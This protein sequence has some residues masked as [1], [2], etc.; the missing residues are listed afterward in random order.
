MDTNKLTQKTKILIND[1]YALAEQNRNLV[2]MPE[3]ILS[4]ALRKSYDISRNIIASC[5]DNIEGVAGDVKAAIDKLPTGR[6]AGTLHFDPGAGAIIAAGIQLAGEYG[7]SFLAIDVLMHAIASSDT[8]P[9]KILAGHGATTM[10]IKAAI[11]ALRG[12]QTSDS[13]NFEET[14]ESLKKYGTD[15]TELASRGKLDPVIGRDDE[16]ERAI[17]ILSMRKKNNPVLIGEPGVGKTAIVE[18]LAQRIFRCEVPESIK[19][20]KVISLDISGLLAGAKFRGEFE[21][22]LKSVLKEAMSSRDII[23]FIDEIHSIIGAGATEGGSMDASNMLKP[24]LARGEIRCIGATT[25]DEYRM[26]IERDPAL[27]RRFQPI[28]L[29]QPN[30]EDVLAILRGLK[31]KYELFHGVQIQ[32]GALVATTDLARHIQGRFSPDKEIDIID[33]ASSMV[34]SHVYSKPAPI[35]KLHK[36]IMRLQMEQSSLAKETSEESSARANEI[37]AELLLLTKERDDLEGIWQEERDSITNLTAAKEQLEQ[38]R[39]ELQVAQKQSNWTRAGEL[40]YSTI[41]ELEEKIRLMSSKIGSNQFRQ[42]VTKGTVA[43]VVARM[44]GIPLDTIVNEERGKLIEMESHLEKSVVGQPIALK[45]VANAIRRARTGMQDPNR[46][47]GSFLFL[48]PT[49]VGKTELAKALARFLFCDPAAILRIDMSEYMEKH[50]VSNLI[51]APPGYVGY[52]RGGLLTETTR[53]RPYQI[54]L[55]D[56][57]EK[58]HVEVLNLLL[59]IL[60]EGHVTDGRGNKVSFKNTIIILTSNIGSEVIAQADDVS[61]VSGEVM[62]VVQGVLSPEFINRL[63][64][65]V[66]FNKLHISNMQDI[67]KIQ[68]GDLC[69]RIKNKYNMDL[70]VDHKVVEFLA[71]KGYDPLYGA[72]PLKRAIQHYLQDGLSSMILGGELSD[73]CSVVVTISN[74]QLKFSVQNSGST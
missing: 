8:V 71:E 18:G 20:A 62:R 6:A 65:I 54:V 5:V 60:D 22:R 74:E 14:R 36:Q 50:S 67:I 10:K 29:S 31:E 57:I 64:E 4:V 19:N 45:A 40:M 23:L 73:G 35:S 39:Q 38:I 72:R 24:H 42:E 47:L 9:S 66:L 58:A 37:A 25:L 43:Q 55:F 53:R 1:S 7:D 3:H 59:Q 16:I 11:L 61:M 34:R 17:Q 51:G 49:G 63:D 41:P 33:E 28:F 70:E 2:V 46:P 48:G 56:E 12:G 27:A 15:L 21:E 26:H 13:E 69:S 30:S 32:D 68:L 44:T 52:E